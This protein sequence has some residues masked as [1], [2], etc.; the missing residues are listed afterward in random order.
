MQAQRLAKK[1]ESG[2]NRAQVLRPRFSTHRERTTSFL[3][4]FL[5]TIADLTGGSERSNAAA[6]ARNPINLTAKT[7]L[8]PSFFFFFFILAARNISYCWSL[9]VCLVICPVFR[10]DV[11]LEGR[12]IRLDGYFFIYSI[13]KQPIIV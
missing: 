2:R 9:V 6:G 13:M 4:V 11:W 1:S 3:L 12:I 5:I 7:Y 10:L 8:C